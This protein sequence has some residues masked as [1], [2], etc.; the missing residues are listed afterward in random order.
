MRQPANVLRYLAEQGPFPSDH[1][2]VK[3]GANRLK[4]CKN[5]AFRG[6]GL[7]E[8]VVF[9]LKKISDEETCSGFG[10]A[11]G[12]SN[13][14]IPTQGPAPDSNRAIPAQVR[15]SQGSNPG[16]VQNVFPRPGSRVR[17]T[18]VKFYPL[19]LAQRPSNG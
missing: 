4:K 3:S 7:E 1:S 2:L 9:R 13:E 16:D 12:R 19:H 6:S 14:S 17:T 15:R 8:F 5:D 18:L 11:L 10:P